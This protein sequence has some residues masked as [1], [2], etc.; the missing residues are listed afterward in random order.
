V[1]ANELAVHCS[2]VAD[3]VG[4]VMVAAA[5]PPSSPL[6]QTPTIPRRA[7]ILL[8]FMIVLPSNCESVADFPAPKSKVAE[9][10]RLSVGPEASRKQ[11]QK[12]YSPL[13]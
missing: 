11:K 7:V 12:R 1:S 3:A 9:G 5:N 6:A 4:A 10:N 13:S 2:G 8:N